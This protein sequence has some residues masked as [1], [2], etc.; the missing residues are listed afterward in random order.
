MSRTWI[1]KFRNKSQ[2]K[3][4]PW[5]CLSSLQPAFVGNVS[6]TVENLLTHIAQVPTLLFSTAHY[7]LKKNESNSKWI[8]FTWISAIKYYIRHMYT[9]IYTWRKNN[10]PKWRLTTVWGKQKAEIPNVISF[11]K[12]GF[13]LLR[14]FCVCT[15]LY[16]ID[17]PYVA[18]CTNV[19]KLIS[20]LPFARPFV[21]YWRTQRHLNL[22]QFR[23]NLCD[24]L[25]YP[26]EIGGQNADILI[27][28]IRA[29]KQYNMT[30]SSTSWKH[31]KQQV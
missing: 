13:P 15:D 12:H 20:E 8:N 7:S 4:I 18:A 30:A 14:K 10:K 3:K 22:R 19:K 26:P 25:R 5:S 28:A 11:S 9:N 29:E 23:R 31:L 16:L 2:D 27:C 24:T 1:N 6:I 21:F 17:S